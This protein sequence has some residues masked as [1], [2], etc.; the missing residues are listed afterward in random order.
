MVTVFCGPPFP[1]SSATYTFD[2]T[3]SP[4]QLRAYLTGVS[5]GTDA[6]FVF[7]MQ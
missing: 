3:S 5:A 1:A 2:A 4:K 6:A 7:D